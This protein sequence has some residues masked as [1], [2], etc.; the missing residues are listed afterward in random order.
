MLQV[1]T[2]AHRGHALIALSGPV[3]VAL[4]D[5]DLYP[6]AHASL[7]AQ[8]AASHLHDAL[9]T[10]P[11]VGLFLDCSTRGP[12]LSMTEGITLTL[13]PWGEQSTVEWNGPRLRHPVDPCDW[14]IITASV[15]NEDSMWLPLSNG[16]A[17]ASAI[18]IG[19]R[20][21][22][23]THDSLPELSPRQ[24]PAPL[25]KEAPPISHETSKENDVPPPPRP[26]PKHALPTPNFNEEIPPRPEPIPPA[27]PYP[28]LGDMLE[29]D[30]ELSDKT[31][32]IAQLAELR[33]QRAEKAAAEQASAEPPTAA[34]MP[35]VA[36]SEATTQRHEPQEMQEAAHEAPPTTQTT[37]FQ[38]QGL[39]REGHTTTTS[40]T[41]KTAHAHTPSAP[42]APVAPPYTPQPVAQTSPAVT[43]PPNGPNSLYAQIFGIDPNPHQVALPTPPPA[44]P[45]P[46]APPTPQGQTSAPQMPGASPSWNSA[47]GHQLHGWGNPQTP[48]Q[49]PASSSGIAYL[50]RGGLKPVAIRGAAVIGREPHPQAISGIA[51]AQTYTVPSPTAEISRSHC[52][53]ILSQGTWLLLDLGSR[54]GTFIQR[55]SGQQE[56][57]MSGLS[58]PISNGDVIGLGDGVNVEFH[59]Q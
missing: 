56:H 7:T 33:R 24:E 38:K 22:V 57:L 39:P 50:L 49:Q 4:V 12:R 26:A 36:A 19:V 18:R 6:Q 2:I 28:H 27:H 32:T 16:A 47:E 53:V 25:T 35:Q 23:P 45:S 51:D 8:T 31:L 34:Q 9:A 17:R 43:S 14:E 41:A 30:P 15:D 42:Q 11:G 37:P 5:E 59:I 54:N 46:F 3:G 48:I 44:Q 10:H 29:D 58:T 20:P 55:A 21:P 1:G 52:A 40:N 13:L